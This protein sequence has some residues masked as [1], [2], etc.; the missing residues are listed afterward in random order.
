M[1]CYAVQVVGCDKMQKKRDSEKN[2]VKV[3]GM[4]F[5]VSLYAVPYNLRLRHQS[6]P[7]SRLHI[8][9]IS[10]DSLL[11]VFADCVNSLSVI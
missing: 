9:K 8:H 7:G 3:K 10:G 1:Y 2:K 6:N 11:Q 4:L 5:Y